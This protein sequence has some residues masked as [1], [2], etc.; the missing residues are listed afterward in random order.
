LK[1]SFIPSIKYLKIFLLK[2]K[3]GFQSQ[4]TAL[5]GTTAPIV[6]GPTWRIS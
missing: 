5:G 6:G 3:K 4:A 2:N 1:A